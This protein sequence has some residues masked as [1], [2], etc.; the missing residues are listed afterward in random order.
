M[1]TEQYNQLKQLTSFYMVK[2]ELTPTAT[3]LILTYEAPMLSTDEK[4]KL[5]SLQ[6]QTILKW[7]GETFK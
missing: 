1:S 2:A 3:D 5:N 6:K 7:N 4:K